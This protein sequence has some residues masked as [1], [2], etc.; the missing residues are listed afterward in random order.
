MASDRYIAIDV[1]EYD[2]LVCPDCNSNSFRLPIID[3]HVI[4]YLCTE[5]QLFVELENE[6]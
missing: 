4:G 2:E 5:C 6:S 1:D 3:G